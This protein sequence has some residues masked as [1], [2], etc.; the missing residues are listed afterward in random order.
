[1]NLTLVIKKG[2]SGFL[3][4][5]LKEFPEVFTQGITVD[6][7]KENILD[8]LDMYLE[9]AREKFNSDDV[10]YLQELELNFS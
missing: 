7:V 10:D 1:M 2:R 3:I 9:E 4:G 8:A 6:E 5:R